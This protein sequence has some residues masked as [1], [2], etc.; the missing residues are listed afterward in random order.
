MKITFSANT[1]VATLRRATALAENIEAKQAELRALLSGQTSTRKSG[2]SVKKAS[3]FSDA[4]RALIS[5]GLKRKWAERKA[6][7]AASAT[8]ATPAVT[9]TA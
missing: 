5:E 3:R 8:P 6:A 2:K 4:Q 7:K 1:S 9:A